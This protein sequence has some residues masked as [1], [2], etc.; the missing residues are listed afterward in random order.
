MRECEGGREGGR[1]RERGREGGRER[2]REREG[3]H[4]RGRES[5]ITV[6]LKPNT[7]VSVEKNICTSLTFAYSTHL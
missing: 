7:L 1:E 3:G 2:E 5:V 6:L 4:E